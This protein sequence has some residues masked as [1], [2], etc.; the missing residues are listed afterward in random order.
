MYVYTFTFANIPWTAHTIIE[1][2]KQNT[3]VRNIYI[4]L[5]VVLNE[6]HF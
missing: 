2:E 6:D 3:S 1:I 5:Y 4:K